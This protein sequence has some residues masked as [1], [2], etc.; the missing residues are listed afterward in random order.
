MASP[1]ISLS[2]GFA[3][4]TQADWLALV[5]KTLKGA[6]ADTLISRTTDGLAV[7]PLYVAAD[8]AHALS[9]TP[10]SRGGDAA[11]DIRAVVAGA[12]IATA[13]SAALDA[14]AGGAASIL[15]RIGAAPGTGAPVASADDL[16]RLLEGVMTDVAPVALDAGALGVDAALWLSQA[17]KSAPAA[18][19]ALH[20]DPLGALAASGRSAGPVEGHIAAAARVGVSLA[21]TYPRA[22]L[23]LASGVV[24]HEAGASPTWE[25]AFATASAVAYAKALVAAGL[26]VGEAFSRIVLGFAA[27][28]QPLTAISKLRAARLLWARVVQACGAPELVARIEARSSARMLTRADRW[29]NLIRLTSAGFGAAVGGA[30][31]I[32]LGAFTDAL[33]APDAFALRMA[34][35]TQLILMDEAHLGAVADPS[36]GA[37]AVE[38]LTADLAINAWDAFV[39]IEKAGGAAAALAGGLLAEHVANGR[40][41]LEADLAARTLRLIGVTDFKAADETV[42]AP[43]ADAEGPELPAPAPADGPDTVCIPLS[44]IRLEALAQ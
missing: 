44:P 25:L 5:E 2:D 22:S 14:L 30:D 19:L 38:A 24:A 37:W 40:A 34:R 13:N 32:V 17:A 27:E 21:E 11:W 9:F 35:N 33:G 15:V 1:V 31:A 43:A 18:A 6:S 29:T 16:R 12:D 7:R 26:T 3:A 4:P 36:G 28:A 20:I 41:A 42:P 10:A 23:F 8:A 39:A